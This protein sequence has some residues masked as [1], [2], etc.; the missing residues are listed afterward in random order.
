MELLRALA[1]RIEE[2]DRTGELLDAVPELLKRLG[3]AS[4][5][6]VS[7][8]S[9][10]TYDTPEI[11]ESRRIVDEATRGGSRSTSRRTTNHGGGRN[12]AL[13]HW[14][15]RSSPWGAA[16]SDRLPDAAAAR[17]QHPRQRHRCSRPTPPDSAATSWAPTPRR[18][19]SPNTPT[20]S[21]RP[22]RTSRPC[23]CPRSRSG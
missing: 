1:A 19:R 14:S 4:Q 12:E 18:S 2:L 15:S 7:L 22:A 9:P 3:D 13:L 8:R 6:I 16:G 5:R 21:V 11:A 10:T 17:R 20:T 23:R